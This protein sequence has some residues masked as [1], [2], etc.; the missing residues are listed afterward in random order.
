MPVG[1]E[2]SASTANRSGVTRHSSSSS[3]VSAST[4]SSPTSTDAARAERPAAR[5]RSRPT[6]RGG[7]PASARR[8]RAPR[9]GP[10]ARRP[11]RRPAA[12]TSASAAASAA[13][14]RRRPR[15]TSRAARPSWAGEPRSS[16]SAIARSASR[17]LLGVGLERVLAP[18]ARPPGR[19]PR[20]HARGCRSGRSPVEEGNARAGTGVGGTRTIRSARARRSSPRT[21]ASGRAELE[22]PAPLRGR[23]RSRAPRPRRVVPRRR[24][25][26]ARRVPAPARRGRAPGRRGGRAA[27]ARA[28]ATATT[29]S[30]TPVRRRHER[31]RR[32]RPRPR[33]RHDGAMSLDLSRLDRVLEVDPISRAA[34]I[35]AGATGPRI[36]EQ[37]AEH[38]MTLRFFPQSFER[39][40]LGGWIA[41]RAAGPLRHRADPHRR[42][43]RVGPRG[44]A[45]RRGVGVAP[46]AGVR[47]RPVAGPPA[48]RLR[49]HAG[50]DHRGVGARPPARRAAL[51]RPRRARRLRDRARA[52][53][54]D[55]PVR[56]AAV[57]LPADRGARGAADV[58]RRAGR[59]C[60]SASRATS[61]AV[62]G[63]RAPLR[64]QA[65]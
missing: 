13:G 35:Q 45:A 46:P 16:S 34:R 5:P 31:G 27:R 11:R 57:E 37:L 61:R 22:R 26:A 23:P 3:R 38:G 40:T 19:A 32:R 18:A 10:T 54:G 42:P 21:W 29:S 36:E 15:T 14:H 58:R 53:P 39:S 6:A 7:R 17:A 52:D 65:T 25:R 9:T 20:G 62:D 30:V 24:A 33:P 51:E 55:R 41:T 1:S 50:G 4:G 28:R 44:H 63:R 48:A 43:R 59:T 56:A 49:G 8:R 60:S 2:T 47:R 64:R 12:P